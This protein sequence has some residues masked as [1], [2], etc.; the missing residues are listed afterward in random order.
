MDTFN[1]CSIWEKTEI[2]D[3]PFLPFGSQ[4]EIIATMINE[5]TK[6]IKYVKNGS[7]RISKGEFSEK[8]NKKFFFY[9]TDTLIGVD[10]SSLETAGCTFL[11]QLYFVLRMYPMVFINSYV[12]DALKGITLHSYCLSHHYILPAFAGMPF[13]DKATSKR[14]NNEVIEELIKG[15]KKSIGLKEMGTEMCTPTPKEIQSRFPQFTVD[16]NERISF[17]PQVTWLGVADNHIIDLLNYLFNENIVEFRVSEMIEKFECSKEELLFYIDESML[18][19]SEDRENVIFRLIRE[20]AYWGF[21][22]NSAA[23]F[24]QEMIER[25]AICY[26]LNINQSLGTVRDISEK[27]YHKIGKMF[28]KKDWF[29]HKL[30]SNIRRVVEQEENPNIVIIDNG[31]MDGVINRFSDIGMKENVYRILDYYG[32][33]VKYPNDNYDNL[34][35]KKVLVVTD[36]INTGH[37]ICSAVDMLEKTGCKD[38][39]IFAFIINQKLDFGTICENKVK[40]FFFLTEK[41]LVDISNILDS[42]YS[43]RF[44]IDNNLK[45]ELLWGEVGKNILLNKNTN[46]Q[47][48]YADRSENQ[49]EYFEY[50]FELKDRVDT[51]SY[52]YQKI[53]RL[54]KQIDLI[55]VYAQYSGMV[56]YI[57]EICSNE[58]WSEKDTQ[59]IEEKEIQLAKINDEYK[60]KEILLVFPVG[61]IVENKAALERFK[62]AN[63]VKNVMIL[64]LVNFE[65]Y[66]LDKNALFDAEDTDILFVFNSKLKKYVASANNPQI[67]EMV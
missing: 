63:E 50:N 28:I 12:N 3:L 44:D 56:S 64:N 58:K 47:V 54:L 67:E 7:F 30:F 17:V 25:D 35:D 39:I 31:N 14:Y 36:I 29:A 32:V 26:D 38:I 19:Y 41:A 24:E 22:C 45:F 9:K 15:K 57:K 42:E 55:L 33:A 1:K 13:L 60:G 4:D 6:Y 53:K 61:F 18:F 48:T 49:I 51:H 52:I 37:L 5:S 46:P 66:S 23:Q 43:K 27:I 20:K 11:D 21:V 16:K 40:K 62:R 59:T 34:K 8:M 2:I 65:V 10:L